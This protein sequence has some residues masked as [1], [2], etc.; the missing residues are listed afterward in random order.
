MTRHEFT[1][2][3]PTLAEYIELT[4]RRVT[5]IY[6]AD[7]SLIV[8]LLDI[9]VSPP[10]LSEDGPPL[11]ILEAGTGHGSLTLHLARAVHAAN[12]ARPPL[13]P[14][15]DV[16]Y[17]PRAQITRTVGVDLG[18]VGDALGG[19]QEPRPAL[20]EEKHC[21]FEEWRSARGAIVHTIDI[22]PQN[23]RHAEHTIRGFQRGMYAG[24]V[25]FHT[26]DV[27]EWVTVQLQRRAGTSI[28]PSLAVTSPAANLAFLSQ[29]FLDIPDVHKNLHRMQDALY[30][31][32]LLVV[33]SP[34]VTQIA[35]CVQII[36]EKKL[37]F[38]MDQVVELGLATTGLG[39][40]RQWDVRVASTAAER[41]K[42]RKSKLRGTRGSV[43]RGRPEDQ[44]AARV[45]PPGQGETRDGSMLSSHTE[46]VIPGQELSADETILEMD[47]TTEDGKHELKMVCRPKVGEKLARLAGGGFVAVWRRM[48]DMRAPGDGGTDRR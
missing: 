6:P 31:D 45:V 21:A 20:G 16:P 3:H 48:R 35:A 38:A 27:S 10:T 28:D 26:G 24:N 13:P 9:H 11:E 37:L 44:V 29:I 14:M 34:S 22:D 40:G 41:A 5:P 8:S 42:S 39:S 18:D 2:H 46:G 12:I 7:A 23:S 15:Q 19:D 4:P 1:I 47:P 36:R 30:V 32:G 33:F 43:Q 25:E 17:S